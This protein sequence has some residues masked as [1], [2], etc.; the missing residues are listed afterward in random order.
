MAIKFNGK[1]FIK[2]RMGKLIVVSSILKRNIQITPSVVGRPE[3]VK[4]TW[5]TQ[6]L[7]ESRTGWVTGF[8]YFQNG[9]L[10]IER[11]SYNEYGIEY[12][13]P[14]LSQESN[15]PCIMVVFWP[16]MNPVPV[17]MDGFRDFDKEKDHEPYCSSN[18]GVGIQNREIARKTLSEE[19]KKWGTPE[20]DER[21]RF[22]GYPKE[23]F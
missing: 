21:G 1:K 6:K 4:V 13:L 7:K 15:V 5:I 23:L 8:R 10:K 11:E 20:R 14:Y 12:N 2:E 9:T 16:T 19:M 3:T 22:K 18:L 17:P